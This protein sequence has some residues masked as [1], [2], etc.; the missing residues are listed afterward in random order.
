MFR[1]VSIIAFLVTFLGIALHHIAFLSGLSE[2]R[3]GPLEIL[4]KLVYL[5]T[6]LF[7]EQRLSLL[8]K[9]KK[10]VYL[11]T[12]LCFLILAVTGF[13][14]AIVLGEELSGYLS[15]LHVT[16]GGVFAACLALLA[17]MWAHQHRFNEND[18]PWLIS[19]VRHDARGMF[20]PERSGLLRKI[21]F[22]LIVILALPIMLSIVL[23]MFGLFG[24]AGPYFLADTHRYCA[25]LFAMVAIVHIYLLVRRTNYE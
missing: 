19:L 23:S 21:C 15:V 12:L 16:A 2:H 24:T 14:P 9:L 6:L 18:W 1:I 5:L 7:L 25:L 11:L 13:Y 8:G 20:L 10:L 4:K 22:W 17:L 3:W